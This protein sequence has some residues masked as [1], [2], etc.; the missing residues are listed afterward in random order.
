MRQEKVRLSTLDKLI[1]YSLAIY[2][3]LPI[4]IFAGY[5]IFGQL[6]LFG[7]DSSL[8]ILIVII[9]GIFLGP[10]SLILYFI[11]RDKLKFELINAQVNSETFK[12]LI[13]EIS[14]E[15]KWTIRSFENGTFI[16]KTNPGFINQSWGQHITLK[17]GTGGILVNSI[18]DP[19]KGSW[20]I[21]FG[22]NRKN[23]NGIHKLIETRTKGQ[24]L[25]T[26]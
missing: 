8:D 3:G 25:E 6:G 9:P 13:R 10:I 14:K 18:F 19:N 11:Q 16:I 7:L 12:E 1:H 17:L 20:L 23:I 4:L 5:F 21:T 2:F 15:Y 22:S 26:A 24:T